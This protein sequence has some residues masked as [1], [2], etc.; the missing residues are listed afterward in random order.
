[1]AFLSQSNRSQPV[2][3]NKVPRHS[4][5]RQMMQQQQ[6]QQSLLKRPGWPGIW[7]ADAGGVGLAVGPSHALH[8]VSTV[9]AIYTF[10]PATGDQV[11]SKTFALQDLFAPVRAANCR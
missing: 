3:A 8:T 5:A 2:P 1:L 7:W 6:Q 10:D 9:L 11:A 4:R